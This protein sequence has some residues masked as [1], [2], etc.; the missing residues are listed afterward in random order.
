VYIPVQPSEIGPHLPVHA[1]TMAIGGVHP[2]A[3]GPTPPPPQETLV[4]EQVFTQVTAWLQLFVAG[5]QALPLQAAVL[6][7]VHPQTLATPL[8]AQV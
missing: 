3:F 7:G 5:P 2:H 8:P 4:P 6:S 1:A